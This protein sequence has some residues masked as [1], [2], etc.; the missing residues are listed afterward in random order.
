M[1]PSRRSIVIGGGV[2]AAGATVAGA[3]YIRSSDQPGSEE[4]SSK[5]VPDGSD[6]LLFFNDVSCMADCSTESAVA[7]VILE[8]EQF[9]D[10]PSGVKRLL[11]V[12]SA[13]PVATDDVGKIVLIGGEGQTESGAIIWADWTEDELFDLNDTTAAAVKNE[14]YR[15]RP[16]YVTDSTAAAMVSNN[17]FAV[18][19]RTVVHD[20][21]DT[22][23]GDGE[24]LGGSILNSFERTSRSARV[25][26]S[27]NQLSLDCDGGV[28]SSGAYDELQQTYGWVSTETESLHIGLQAKPTADTESIATALRD[29]LGLSNYDQGAALPDEVI[30]DITVTHERDSVMIEYVRNN[31][32]MLG[33]AVL[34]SVLCI[35]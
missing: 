17:V 35:L 20:I 26:F 10:L 34:R 29:D 25:R 23:H 11:D 4:F 18:G 3:R 1:A 13:A 31:D 21:L 7:T 24:P 9:R 15:N 28:S 33:G 22:W 6:P 12:S 2:L 14:P 27:F 8:A 30:N 19:S 32:E 16:V 5:S